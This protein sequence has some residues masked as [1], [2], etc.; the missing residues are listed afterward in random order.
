MLGLGLNITS[1]S[2]AGNYFT[3]VLA[4]FKR[5]GVNAGFDTVGIN[6]MKNLTELAADGDEDKVY[7]LTFNYY[8]KYYATDYDMAAADCVY[9]YFKTAYEI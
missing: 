1:A 2:L 9:N 4:A 5:R 7:L 8:T 6:C 3:D